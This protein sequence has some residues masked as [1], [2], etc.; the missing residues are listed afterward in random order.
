MAKESESDQRA[1]L[2]PGPSWRSL[3]RISIRPV[4]VVPRFRVLVMSLFLGGSSRSR[5]HVMQ[6]QHVSRHYKDALTLEAGRS[7]PW[8]SGELRGPRGSSVAPG[9]SRSLLGELRGSSVALGRATSG[10]ARS[11]R[12]SSVALLCVGSWPR[13]A[14]QRLS[15]P[16]VITFS[17]FL[18]HLIGLLPAYRPRITPGRCPPRLK[19]NPLT[20]NRSMEILR[21]I[22]RKKTGSSA[23]NTALTKLRTACR[24]VSHRL[25]N[26]S[27]AS[28]G[29][30]V[31]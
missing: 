26:S 6:P 29:R 27:S 14:A 12:G 31:Q 2:V 22:L 5:R 25:Q 7:E 1:A 3:G 28:F 11:P 24:A 18:T 23:L 21:E 16:F 15:L 19:T 4:G 20:L 13:G 30:A 8:P 17:F 10:G 9:G